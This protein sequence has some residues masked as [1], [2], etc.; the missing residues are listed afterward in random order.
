[1]DRTKGTVYSAVSREPRVLIVWAELRY[2]TVVSRYDCDGDN[3]TR[4]C[5]RSNA[6]GRI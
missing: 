2:F 1:M 6:N 5:S 4:D 3:R